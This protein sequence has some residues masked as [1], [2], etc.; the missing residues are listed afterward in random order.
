MQVLL[1]CD[2]KTNPHISLGDE[3][4]YIERYNPEYLKYII[5]SN[6]VTLLFVFLFQQIKLI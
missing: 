5:Y 1:T 6:F 2:Y 3:R 4:Y